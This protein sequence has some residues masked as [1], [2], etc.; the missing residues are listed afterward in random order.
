ME[1]LTD[2]KRFNF[3]E[4][5]LKNKVPLIILLIGILVVSLGI[6]ALKG[7]FVSQDKVEVLEGT[8]EGKTNEFLIV[9]VSGA[10]T[11]PA[12]Y[13]MAKDSRVEDA[14][15]AAG[16]LTVGADR[17][18]VEKTLNR[19][20][21]ISDGQKIFIPETGE[22]STYQ[23]QQSTTLG[24]NNSGVYQN[25][26]VVQGSGL[27]N[28]NTAT[29]KELEALNGIGPVYAQKIIEQRPYSNIEDL[30]SKKVIPKSTYEKIKN[31]ISV[32]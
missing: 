1:E 23:N 32:Y 2:P 25:D 6:F 31:D 20:A 8:T 5:F 4:F 27:T 28:I 13:K 3:E 26:T 19:A 29:Q 14:L 18:W 21:K 9:E 24:A 30:T 17:G 15:V 12:V 16:G 22:N 10:V 7:N 11:N